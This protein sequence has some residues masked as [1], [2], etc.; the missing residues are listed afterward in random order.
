MIRRWHFGTTDLLR[1]TAIRFRLMTSLIALSLLPLVISGAISYHE[2]NEAIQENTRIFASE[3]VKQVANNVRLK[4]QQIETGSEALVLSNQVQSALSRYGNRNGLE[5]GPARAELIRLLLEAYGS[6]DYINQ[7]Y[8]I[9]VDSKV[10]DPQVFPQ[11]GEKVAQLVTRSPRA[12][13]APFW[14]A[15]PVP[16]G[17]GSIVMMRDIYFKENVQLAGSLFLGI[18]PSYFSSVFDNV[19]LGPHSGLAVV[20]AAS[21]RM[22]IKTRVQSNLTHGDALDPAL[23]QHIQRDRARGRDNGFLIHQQAT[24]RW[25]FD[26]EDKRLVVAYTPITDTGWLVVSTIPYENLAVEAQAIRNRIV[27]IG[28]ICFACSIGAAYLIARSISEPLDK[29][30]R[31]M[32]QAEAGNYA[33]RIAQEG[34][35]ELTLLARQFNMMASK[36][37]QAHEQMEKR[38]GERTNALEQANRQL[39]ALS[40]TDSLTGIANRRRFDEILPAELQR[41]AR[42]MQPLALMMIDVDF[43]KSF[44]DFYGHQEGDICLRQVADVLESQ[45]RRAGELAARYG[46]EEFVL[47]LTDGDPVRAFTLAESLRRAIHELHLPHAQSPLDG[48]CVTV[49]IG[50]VVVVPDPQ[51]TPASFIRMADQAM[52]RAKKAGRNQV[53]LYGAEI[54]STQEAAA[55][56]SRAAGRET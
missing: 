25:A 40:Q 39:A 30:I 10:V 51:Q 32:K 37:G 2:S 15:L 54:G 9:G 46:G 19:D 55:A 53:V 47:L 34:N 52:Y 8:F 18:R 5:H 38:V 49:S 31:S 7:K 12:H 27:L 14:T 3:I 22:L 35:D 6:F 11:I 17:P 29:L 28:L 56:I 1:K 13:G 36:I 4:M 16:S 24:S 45:A 42:A 44:N 33:M 21:G 23:L 41:A 50:L 48:A 26:R 43:F 20:E